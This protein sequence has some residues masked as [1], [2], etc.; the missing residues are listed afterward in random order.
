MSGSNLQVLAAIIVGLSALVLFPAG[1]AAGPSAAVEQANESTG[2]IANV[3]QTHAADTVGNTTYVWNYTTQGLGVDTYHLSAG[4]AGASNQSKLCLSQNDTEMCRSVGNNTAL[5][6]AIPNNATAETTQITLTLRDDV[7][8]E[9]LD[10]ESYTIQK[11]SRL[12]D[13]DGDGLSNQEEATVGT[14]ITSADTDGDGLRDGAEIT[15]YGTAPTVSDTDDDGLT[16]SEEVRKHGTSP[17]TVDTD[18]DGLADGREVR[19]GTDPTVADTDT[20][21]LS[22]GAEIDEGSDPRIADTDDDGLDDGR[23]VDLGTDP[24]TADTDSDDLADGRE[25]THGTAPLTADTDGDGLADGREVSLGTDPLTADT[26]DDGL[27]DGRELDVGT[28]PLTADTDGDGILD[29]REV[30]RMAT[31]PTATDSDGDYLSDDIE[32]LVGTNPNS[33]LTPAWLAALLGA[34]AGVGLL[35]GAIRRGHVVEIVDTVGTLQRVFI[36]E[37]GTGVDLQDDGTETSR[38]PNTPEGVAANSAEAVYEERAE[39]SLVTDSELVSEMLVA[40]KGRMKQSKI[41]AV[42]DWSKAKVSR[43][44][45]KKAEAGDIVKLRLGR[46]NLICLE[47]A[48]PAAV[49]SDPRSG[50]GVAPPDGGVPGGI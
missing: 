9:T 29:G 10:T 35:G 21:G 45:S 38:G 17:T 22:D 46:E 8:G 15:E 16:D 14:N 48:Q 11:I 42:T 7:T 24:L 28:A 1:V 41:V 12:G 19:E 4:T 50:D 23:E 26:D 32:V 2:S 40:E 20:D 27:A 31:D 33:A 43:L 30:T 39:S 44:L 34:V 3:S 47:Q 18:G 36:R 5:S 37:R 25:V 49:T 6:F 13:E